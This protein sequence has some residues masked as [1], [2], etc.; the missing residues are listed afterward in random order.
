MKYKTIMLN[1]D[2][3]VRLA[4]AKAAL[5]RRM[6]VSLSFNDLILEL[7]SKNLDFLDI[8]EG[9][10]SH[11]AKFAD[12]VKELDY[13]L[14]I[15]LFGSVAKETS[16]ENSDIDVLVLVRPGGKGHLAKLIDIAASLR[17]DES[18]L[19]E[20]GLPSF[21]SPIL[22]SVDELRKFRPFYL[23]LAD[24]GVIL[25]EKDHLLSNFIYETKRIKHKRELINNTEVLAWR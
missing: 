10:K 20:K 8:D 4:D 18:K 24:Y 3:Y 7:V 25:Y 21:I 5:A 11:I 2:S 22:L 13:V 1:V 19:M 9:L 23:D 14:G 16:G 6:G 12:K 15:L 17:E